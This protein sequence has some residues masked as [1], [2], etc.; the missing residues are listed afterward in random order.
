MNENF[1]YFLEKKA[2]PI[3]DN[4]IKTKNFSPEIYSYNK[5]SE[6]KIIF[7]FHLGFENWI[8]IYEDIII[9]L[10][11]IIDELNSGNRFIAFKEYI[12]K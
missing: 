11:L 8:E 5:T 10:K 6:N 12:S 9:F 7:E 1:K 3:F 2:L 4:V